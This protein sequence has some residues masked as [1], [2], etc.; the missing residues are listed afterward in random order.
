MS[1]SLAASLFLYNQLST[2]INQFSTRTK[3]QL[4]TGLGVDTNR[5][6]RELAKINDLSNVTIYVSAETIHKLYEFIRYGNS[7]DKFLRN[8]KILKN[9]GCNIVLRSVLSNTTIFSIVDFA[10]YFNEY[11]IMYQFCADPD[12]LN[13]NVLDYHTKQQLLHK[14]KNSNITIKDQLIHAVEQSYTDKQKRDLKHYLL[15]FASRRKLSL[16][17]FPLT[18]TNWLQLEQNHVV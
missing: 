2:I 15:E 14:I 16:D 4:S 18:M 5:L 11:E 13:V 3:I 9:S 12:F 8:L 17:V 10:Q 1:I 7:F 6:Q